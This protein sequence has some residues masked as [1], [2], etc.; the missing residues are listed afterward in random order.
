MLN[1]VKLKEIEMTEFIW[2]VEVME[3]HDEILLVMSFLQF[4]FIIIL[5]NFAENFTTGCLMTTYPTEWRKKICVS[6]E[7]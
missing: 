1:C 3:K 6:D 2:L 4:C 7:L 5:F